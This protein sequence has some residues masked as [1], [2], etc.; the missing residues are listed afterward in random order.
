MADGLT[1]A[2]PLNI[3]AVAPLPPWRT[4][5]AVVCA[6]LVGALAARGHRVR[7]LAPITPD[8]SPGAF[9]PGDISGTLEISWFPVPFFAPFDDAVSDEYRRQEGERIRDWLHRHIATERPDVVLVGRG[10]YGP[11]V[12]PIM[13]DAGIPSVVISHGG[14]ATRSGAGDVPDGPWARIV[15]SL[16]DADLLVAPAHHWADALRRRGL[17]RVSVIPNPVDLRRFAPRPPDAKL[18]RDLEVSAGNVVLLHASNLQA[19]KRPMDLLASAERAVQLDPRLVYV[20]VGDGP[21]RERL[22]SE[23]RR[24]GLDRRF[25]F[26]RWVDH[27][28]MPDFLSLADVV[29]MMSEQETQS[30]VY[31]ETQA[32]G[33]VLLASDVPGAREVVVDG[34]TGVLFRAGDVDHLAERTIELARRPTWRAEL[35]SRA[36]ECVA[37]HALPAIAQQYEGALEATASAGLRRNTGRADGTG[38]VGGRAWP[39]QEG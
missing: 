7:T 9:S 2:M 16:A 21:L 15:A 34:K 37:P 4:G 19:V 32:A 26:V 24:L 5:A 22:M 14:P 28:R 35:G 25:R 8:S 17:Q 33:R 20:V 27:D 11:Y 31:L 23:G 13:R 38:V 30:L 1:A 6:R 12:L 36:R 39:R 10:A 18:A 3:V 29:V